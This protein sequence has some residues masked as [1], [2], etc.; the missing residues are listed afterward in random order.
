MGGNNFQL[1]QTW[2]FNRCETTVFRKLLHCLA[3]PWYLPPTSHIS[4]LALFSG[5]GEQ[6]RGLFRHYILLQII[7]WPGIAVEL[8]T[9]FSNSLPFPG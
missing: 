9:V 2:I 3:S 1:L 5:Q 7:A 4:E 6:T 8:P